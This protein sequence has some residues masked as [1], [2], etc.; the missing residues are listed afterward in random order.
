MF[1]FKADSDRSE[2]SAD[3]ETDILRT[4]V[5]FSSKKMANWFD[6][7]AR[8]LNEDLSLIYLPDLHVPVLV[9]V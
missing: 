5:L 4:Y 8:Q 9:G 3:V 1:S 2:L 7:R 6:I